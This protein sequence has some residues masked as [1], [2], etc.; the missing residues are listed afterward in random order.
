VDAPTPDSYWVTPRLLAGKY[1]ALRLA[2]LLDAGVSTFVDLTA[3]GEREPY[4]LEL[5]AGVRHHRIAVRD[6]TC[7]E[8]HQVRQALDLISDAASRGSVVYVHCRGGCGRTGVVVGCYLVE[9]GLEGSA[10]L[11]RVH[12]LT[13]VL[14]ETPCPE[15]AAQRDRVSTWPPAR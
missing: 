14:W 9:Q 5:P 2:A 6:F 7:P 4:A 15:S 1:P 3:D 10:A 13:Q 8:D 11:E 12:A